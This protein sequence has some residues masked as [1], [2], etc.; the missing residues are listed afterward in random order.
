M[1][2]TAGYRLRYHLVSVMSSG[3]SP[4]SLSPI[5]ELPLGLGKGQIKVK[6]GTINYFLGIVDSFRSKLSFFIG[7]GRELTVLVYCTLYI[8]GSPAC[9]P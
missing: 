8:G 9:S 1:S 7:A 5:P 2:C 4:P 6:P 3:G